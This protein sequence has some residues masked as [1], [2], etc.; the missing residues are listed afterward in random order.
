MVGFI[1][2]V[3]WELS[4]GLY[5]TG[6]K[7]Q[8]EEQEERE[9]VVEEPDYDDMGQPFTKEETDMLGTILTGGLVTMD[10]FASA[11][12]KDA[13]G[14]HRQKLCLFC[15]KGVVENAEHVYWDCEA[16]LECRRKALRIL[17]KLSGRMLKRPLEHFSKWPKWLKSTGLV[18]CDQRRRT[19]S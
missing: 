11:G 15:N 1:G 4:T 2:N 5:R 9:V 3:D 10:R 6:N 19:S 17:E 16:W 12:L 7:N 18:P 14:G 13:W 8:A